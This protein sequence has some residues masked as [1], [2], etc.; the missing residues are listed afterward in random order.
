VGLVQDAYGTFEG[1]YEPSDQAERPKEHD[2]AFKKLFKEKSTRKLDFLFGYSDN[3]RVDA[4][5]ERIG[6][7]VVTR[8][9]EVR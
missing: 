9:P 3:R 8:R 5:G 4:E 2:D 6:H 7:V 1:M